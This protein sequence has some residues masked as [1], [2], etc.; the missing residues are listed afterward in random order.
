MKNYISEIFYDTITSIITRKYGSKL[1]D[2][3]RMAKVDEYIE[4]LRLGNAFT[5]D[6]TQS[7]IDK[8]GFNNVYTDNI[9]GKS[10]YVLA[11]SG[12]FGKAKI[13]YFITRNKDEIDTAY[14]EQ[15]YDELRR[16]AAG[17]N[18]FSA[19]NYKNA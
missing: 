10:V 7:L 1:N 8:K 5:V 15:I 9:N 13:C 6:Q 3:Q 2:S 16:Q 17:E 19:P 14:L 12:L 18:V 4:S 11:K